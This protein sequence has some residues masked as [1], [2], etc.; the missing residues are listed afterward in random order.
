M[1]RREHHAACRDLRVGEHL[2]VVVDR[3][4]RNLA[5]FEH[6]EPVAARGWCDITPS[7]SAASLVALRMRLALSANSLA[8][9]HSGMPERVA[10]TLKQAIGVGA[11]RDVAVGA[12]DGLIRRAHPMSRPH[13]L[14]RPD[15]GEVFRR[16]PHR[17][18]D[19]RLH[20]RRVDPLTA[21]GAMAVVQRRENAG[22]REERRAEIG[23]GIPAFTGARRV[24]P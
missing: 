4:A 10:E 2:R 5:G 20:E 6:L 22:Q 1:L 13:R 3:A 17:Q 18:R 8:S 7:I 9:A 14:R 24:R 16:L 23:D 21:P 15:P 12:P 19:T 11:N